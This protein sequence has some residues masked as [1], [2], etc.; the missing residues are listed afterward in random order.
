M[1][2]VVH[3]V[4]QLALAFWLLVAAIAAAIAQT[5][6]TTPPVTPS[7]ATS[8]RPLVMAGQEGLFQRII[9]RPGAAIA[10]RPEAQAPSRPVPGF[11]V[12]YVYERKQVG[13]ESWLEVGDA[14]DRLSSWCYSNAMPIV[15]P[16]VDCRGAA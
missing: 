14:D 11:S 3:R 5:P 1:N 2:S 6:P 8:R 16:C 4:A 7:E 9:V 15:W 10:E 12:F 13:Q